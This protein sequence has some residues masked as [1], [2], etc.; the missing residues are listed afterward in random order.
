MTIDKHALRDAAEKATGG[1]WLVYEKPVMSYMDTIHNIAKLLHGT[2]GE[3]K[4]LYM[5]NANGLCPALTGTGPNAANNARYLSM[6]SPATTLALLDESDGKDRQM[7]ELRAHANREHHRGFMMACGHMIRHENA[8]Y[9][10]SAEMEIAALRERITELEARTVRIELPCV[11][12]DWGD[13][14]RLMRDACATRFE[15]GCR[16]AGIKCEVV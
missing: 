13:K 10:D 16:N 1:E 8:H 2:E 3:Q 4:V 7:D 6:V 15:D 9:A 12:P 5:I 14:A 11:P